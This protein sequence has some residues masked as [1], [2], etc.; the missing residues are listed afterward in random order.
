MYPLGAGDE[1]FLAA[2]EA[3]AA[4]TSLMAYARNQLRAN[5]FVLGRVL[6]ARRL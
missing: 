3:A 5:S 1:S 4:D 6:Q 2:A